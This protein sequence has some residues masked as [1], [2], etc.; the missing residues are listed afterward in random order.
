MA[1]GT[2]HR[3]VNK[4]TLKVTCAL[5]EADEHGGVVYLLPVALSDDLVAVDR[6][7]VVDVERQRF[8][9][10]IDMLDYETIPTAVVE[11]CAVRLNETAPFPAALFVP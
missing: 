5:F 9:P 10:W 6:E 1:L 3:A 4:I 2:Q 7:V 11:D 8:G